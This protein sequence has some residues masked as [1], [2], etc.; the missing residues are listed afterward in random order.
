M[1]ENDPKNGKLTDA[2]SAL[3]PY[4]EDGMGIGLGGFG[5]DR[6]PMTLIREIADA[7]V[8]DLVLHTFAGGLDVELLLAAGKVARICACHVGLDHFG[9]APLFREAR[10]SGAVFFEEWSEFTQLAAWRAAAEQ[11]PYAVVRLDPATDLLKVNPQIKPA[12]ALWDEGAFAVRAP[13]F[14]LAVLHVE[15]AHPDGWAIAVGDPYLDTVLA[16]AAKR[17]VVS[18]ERI[19]DDSELEARHRDVH[20]L[21]STVDAVVLAPGAALPGSCLPEYMLDLPAMRAYVEA[22]AAGTTPDQLA[23]LLR[24]ALPSIRIEGAQA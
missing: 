17:V 11:A 24:A 10:Q 13:K 21:A 2:A 1:T 8:K 9:L 23:Q 20:L 4:L 6:K 15:A 22:S 19:I 5:L 12:P 14:D 18:A 16:R 7:P 3:R